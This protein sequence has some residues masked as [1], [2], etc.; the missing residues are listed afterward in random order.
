MLSRSLTAGSR[1]TTVVV[2]TPPVTFVTCGEQNIPRE[3]VDRYAADQTDSIEVLVECR[4]DNGKTP[5]PHGAW[6]E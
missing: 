6:D 3:R 5:L 1:A 2:S 4:G